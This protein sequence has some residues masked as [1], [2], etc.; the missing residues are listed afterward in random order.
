LKNFLYG[1]LKYLVNLSQRANP[2]SIWGQCH[3]LNCWE[4]AKA[5]D[6]IP[7]IR[8]QMGQ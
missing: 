3:L 7:I 8:Q 4:E 2:S 1:D 5:T 6:D